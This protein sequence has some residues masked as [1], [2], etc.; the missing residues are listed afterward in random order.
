[1]QVIGRW[2]WEQFYQ[3]PLVKC[4]CFDVCL[5]VCAPDLYTWALNLLHLS[6]KILCPRWTGT[7]RHLASLAQTLALVTRTN[8]NPVFWREGEGEYLILLVGKDIVFRFITEYSSLMDFGPWLIIGLFL[9]W[10]FER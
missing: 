9:Y 3:L 10:I 4:A 1:M 7:E 6:H 2:K 8:K 5:G